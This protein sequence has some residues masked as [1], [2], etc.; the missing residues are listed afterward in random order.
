MLLWHWDV[1]FNGMGEMEAAKENFER[2]IQS[3]PQ[4][5]FYEDV[6]DFFDMIEDEKDDEPPFVDVK[7]ASDYNTCSIRQ[8]VYRPRGIRQSNRSSFRRVS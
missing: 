6:L 8:K 3:D 4:G 1:I 5:E 2:Y 7:S